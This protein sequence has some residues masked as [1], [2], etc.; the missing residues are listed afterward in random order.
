VF[1]T[2]ALLPL[3]LVVTYVAFGMGV[4]F[5]VRG[6]LGTTSHLRGSVALVTPLSQRTYPH[7]PVWCAQA[8]PKN[9]VTALA[10]TG[11]HLTLYALM[12]IYLAFWTQWTLAQTLPVVGLLC[13]SL[14]LLGHR[15]LSGLAAERLAGKKD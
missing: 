4:N 10:A 6:R 11:F 5:N 13:V 15:A 8:W 12:G 7:H 9:R 3:L 2:L 1:T 14:A